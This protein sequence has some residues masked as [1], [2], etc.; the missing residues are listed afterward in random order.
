MNAEYVVAQTSDVPDD[1]H[2]VVEVQGREIGIFNVSGQFYALPNACFHQ[3]GPLCRGAV[4]GTVIAN[5]ETDWKR[6]WVH[7][8]EIIVSPWHSLEFNITTGQCLAFPKRRLP[9][10]H[11]EIDGE[12][13]KVTLPVRDASR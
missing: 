6:T 10:Y 3:N 1:S 12:Q 7:D 11:V 8:G 2:I 4:S 5:L 13:I 9:L